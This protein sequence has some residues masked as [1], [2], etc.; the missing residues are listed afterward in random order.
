[1]NEKPI[2]LTPEQVKRYSRHLIMNDVGS[3]GQR[4]LLD[5]K[6]LILGAGGLGSPSAIYLALAGVGTIGL[7]DFDVVDLSNLQRQV[8]HHTSDVGRSKLE[9]AR[10]NIKA[11][12][13]DINV[14]LHETRLESENAME[15]IGNYDMVINGADNF[16]TRYLVNDACYLLNKPLIDGSILIFDGQSTVFTPGNG[17]YRCLFPS[18][19]PPGMVPNCAEAG[20]LG[21]LT[22]LVGSIQSTEALKYILGIG[23]SLESRLL[24]I[25]ALSMTFREFK[26]KRNPN[27]PLCGDNPSV[28]ELIDYEIFCGITEDTPAMS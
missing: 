1:M 2:T 24:I 5:A 11:Y 9:S 7:V 19:P 16:A 17:C 18:P 26:L 22:G 13:P 20:V 4:K 6:V 23:E 3:S 14:V 15:I 27:C 21:A 8:L 10:D 25:D 12:N 28:T